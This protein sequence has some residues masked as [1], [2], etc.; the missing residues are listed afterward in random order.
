MHTSYRMSALGRITRPQ[1][2][3]ELLVLL[4][5]RSPRPRNFCPL[6]YIYDLHYL[7]TM[8]FGLASDLPAEDWERMRKDNEWNEVDLRD[9]RYNQ[10]IHMVSA[11]SGAEDF[12][13]CHGHKTRSEDLGLARHLDSITAQV[14]FK[15]I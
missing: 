11:A 12:Y 2:W 5:E 6:M 15:Q 4:W 1:I 13:T 7:C 9:N 14:S 10:I 8:C 3:E